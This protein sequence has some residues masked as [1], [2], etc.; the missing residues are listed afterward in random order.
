MPGYAVHTAFAV[1][2]SIVMMKYGIG[3][4]VY[5]VG[6]IVFGAIIV[7][8][9]SEKSIGSQLL[10]FISKPIMILHAVSIRL[11]QW[12]NWN[13]F[14][15]M[16]RIFKHR[17]AVHSI[18]LPIIAGLLY[19]FCDRNPIW[20]FVGCG[21]LSHLLMDTIGNIFHIHSGTKKEKAAY[22]TLWMINILIAVYFIYF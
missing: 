13:I 4:P 12:T 20:L 1:T 11:E 7:D 8:L 21:I 17:G 22:T 16:C 3:D 15:R 19:V 14:K 2:T 9:D 18:S 5:I 10:P 6:G